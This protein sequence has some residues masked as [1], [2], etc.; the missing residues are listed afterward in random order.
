VADLSTAIEQ[1]A[2]TPR[3]V[4]IDGRT[5]ERNAIAELIEA[6]RYLNRG[7]SYAIQKIK[8]PGAVYDGEAS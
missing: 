3:K 5:V 4:T 8:P 2:A 6:D 1:S 7:R